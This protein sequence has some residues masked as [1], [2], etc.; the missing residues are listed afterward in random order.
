MPDKIQFYIGGEDFQE[1]IENGYYYVDKTAYLNKLLMGPNSFKA[2]IFIRPRRFGKT[3]N[4]NM[5][6]AF[7]ELNYQN[8]GDKSYQT[9]LFLDNKYNLA[10]SKNE[11]KELRQSFMG[12]Y[13]VIYFSF[14]SVEGRYYQNALASLLDNIARLYNEFECLQ[15]STKLSSFERNKFVSTYSFCSQIQINLFQKDILLAAERIATTFLY[16]LGS[17]LYK[18]YGRKVIILIDEYDVPLQQSLVAQEKYYTEMLDIIR[19]LY[20]NTFKQSKNIWLKQG[21]VVG[22]LKI[23]Y[24]S[25]FTG[26]N[27][28]TIHGFDDN[29]Y[30]GFFGFT[31][32][33]TQSLLQQCNL[34]KIHNKLTK[35]YDG[36][37]I[38]NEHLFCPWSISNFLAHA[39]EEA[40]SDYNPKPYWINTSSNDIIKLYL[41]SLIDDNACDQ[42][43]IMQELLYGKPQTISLQ[44]FDVYP[45]FLE[46]RM[47][48]NSFMT[49]LLHT[50]YLTFTDDSPLNGNVILRIPNLEIQKCF[51]IKV[52]NL[53]NTSNQTWVKKAK[54]LLTHLL[55]NEYDEACTIINNMLGIFI[56]LRETTYEFFYHGFLYG[57]LSLVVN[58][59]IIRLESEVDT[60]NGYADLIL[61]QHNKL[62]AVILEL[63]KSKNDDLSR[64]AAAN[65]AVEQI[66]K[67]NYAQKFLNLNYKKILGY[68]LGFGGKYCEIKALGN[69]AK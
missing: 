38:G 12:E 37:R 45:N 1:L 9:Q 24:Q 33:E 64:I 26:A 6:K 65:L 28:F 10:I 29:N 52:Q 60:G 55:D 21:I 35:W 27:N 41:E 59:E 8:P 68:G 22:C 23:S 69:L 15:N 31:Y 51:E 44:E 61:I 66:V 47:D 57:I 18:E 5:I 20:V 48:Y 63:K 2:H 30:A 25:I 67:K 40:N 19:K 4:L 11:Y 58:N 14:R 53:Y 16:D 56:S 32:D 62:T 36:Y 17:L 49:L 50:G 42:I 46:P 54:A 13:P 39:I 3:L 34:L 43:N 7:C